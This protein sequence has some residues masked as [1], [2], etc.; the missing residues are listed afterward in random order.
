M[1]ENSCFLSTRQSD[2]EHKT[3]RGRASAGLSLLVYNKSS[4]TLSIYTHTK[5]HQELPVEAVWRN[6]SSAFFPPTILS[7]QI[8]AII[9]SSKASY[10]LHLLHNYVSPEWRN[11]LPTPY[12]Q[13]IPLERCVLKLKRMNRALK[14]TA[15]SISGSASFNYQ[16]ETLPFY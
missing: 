8:K 16:N 11:F 14:G 1:Q 6:T 5:R 15:T 2:I 10:N 7:Q 12:K 13:G 9:C 3:Y 4:G